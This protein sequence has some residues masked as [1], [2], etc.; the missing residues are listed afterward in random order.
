MDALTGQSIAERAFNL[1]PINVPLTLSVLSD[2]ALIYRHR[3]QSTN[4]LSARVFRL[5]GADLAT[6][7]DI[8]ISSTELSWIS[9]FTF[10][11]R[12]AELWVSGARRFG[13]D[14]FGSS[15]AEASAT[16]RFNKQT[17]E[18][19]G[20][21]WWTYGQPIV[22]LEYRNFA[23]V[24]ARNHQN[25]VRSAEIAR[26]QLTLWRNEEFTN[27][28]V[29][30]D[31]AVQTPVRGFGTETV[32]RMFVRNTGSATAR[33]VRIRAHNNSGAIKLTRIGCA[34]LIAPLVC[35]DT[36]DREDLVLTSLAPQA[37]VELW[38]RAQVIGSSAETSVDYN[39]FTVVVIPERTQLERN[40][41][42]NAARVSMLSGPFR[43]GF[44]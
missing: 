18:A 1:G 27:E 26:G 24:I 38:M 4:A 23:D 11:E 5:N 44:E 30:L 28:I 25:E 3:N 2:G 29:D 33:H 12:G 9:P 13:Y 35:G 8:P 17:G 21:Y 14:G 7:F 16:L 31:I 41:A 34:S 10:E 22:P 43:D 42:N 15:N 40:G 39:D 19:L 20:E 37:M 36:D 6:E 32:F